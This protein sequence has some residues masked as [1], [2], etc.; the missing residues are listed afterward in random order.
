MSIV[1]TDKAYAAKRHLIGWDNNSNTPIWDCTREN[2]LREYRQLFEQVLGRPFSAAS[3]DAEPE[4]QNVNGIPADWPV[5]GAVAH[6]VT[7]QFTLAR[8]KSA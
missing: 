3:G 8:P 5:T 1:T 6:V 7:Q 2:L 4:L